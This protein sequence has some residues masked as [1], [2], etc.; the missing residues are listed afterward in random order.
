MTAL[1]SAE[2]FVADFHG[3]GQRMGLD[4]LRSVEDV[5]VAVLPLIRRSRNSFC[6]INRFAPE[7]LVYIFQHTLDDPASYLTRSV[8]APLKV[9]LYGD[10]MDE[11]VQ[12]MLDS[13][14]ARIKELHIHS[15]TDAWSY[16]TAFPAP[17]L[18][19][20]TLHVRTP[21]LVT[22]DGGLVPAQMPSTSG[23]SAQTALFQDNTPHLKVL[24]LHS[25]S[26][27]PRN[28]FPSLTHLCLRAPSLRRGGAAHLLG[29]PDVAWTLS[30][31]QAFLVDCP[32][33]EE[34]ILAEI[35]AQ[36]RSDDE[37]LPTVPLTRLRRF[38]LGNTPTELLVWFAR[39][40]E[41]PGDVAIRIFGPA[42]HSASRLAQILP[43]L[44]LPHEPHIMLL[45]DSESYFAD[46]ILTVSIASAS[47]GIQIHFVLYRDDTRWDSSVWRLFPFADIHELHVRPRRYLHVFTDIASLIERLPLLSTLVCGYAPENQNMLGTILARLSPSP[48][49]PAMHCPALKTLHVFIGSSGEM[50]SNVVDFAAARADVGYPLRRVIIEQD[51]DIHDE[52]HGTSEFHDKV[53]RIREQVE[54]IEVRAYDGIA[55][56]VDWPAV[57]TSG[58]H[59]YWPDW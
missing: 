20:L 45:E 22:R 32:V 5:L 31:L 9:Y 7:L 42:P 34:L 4:E 28:H 14:G 44:P 29:F 55:P 49:R 57:C 3:E 12:R 35:A 47:S 11:Y 2:K 33:L 25:A 21:Q 39:H 1:R 43:H 46:P 53:L 30:D 6:P 52:W 48:E 18:E 13:D 41:M 17:S 37:A 24:S 50:L 8:R 27:L 26:Y 16:L 56:R 38:A 15:T 23:R 40:I 10:T 51:P 36:I 58:T 59:K 54:S 19:H